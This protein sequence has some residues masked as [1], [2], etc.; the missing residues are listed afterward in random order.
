MNPASTRAHGK[1][2]YTHTLYAFSRSGRKSGW[3]LEC[4]KARVEI[5]GGVA[6]VVYI[7]QDRSPKTGDTGFMILTEIDAP[8]PKPIPP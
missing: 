7:Y 5:D 2:P 8:P 4:G 6:H 3:L 1:P